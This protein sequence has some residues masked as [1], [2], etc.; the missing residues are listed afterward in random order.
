MHAPVVV[1]QAQN[2]LF[3]LPILLLLLLSVLS[4]L[5]MES[6]GK[7]ASFRKIDTSDGLDLNGMMAI[8][9]KTLPPDRCV[10]FFVSITSTAF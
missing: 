10:T 8:L 4:Y 5:Q 7:Y 3:P 6:Q 1:V 2:S 9:R